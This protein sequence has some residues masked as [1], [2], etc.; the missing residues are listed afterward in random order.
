MKI[1]YAK[2]STQEHNINLKID[3]LDKFGFNIIYQEKISKN[4]SKLLDYQ[5]FSIRMRSMHKRMNK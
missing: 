3:S 2:V 5:N 4:N 1:G